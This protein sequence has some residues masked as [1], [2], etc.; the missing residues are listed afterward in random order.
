MYYLRKLIISNYIQQ[1]SN[2]LK[3]NAIQ[4]NQIITILLNSKDSKSNSEFY[5]QQENLNSYCQKRKNLS[6]G[7]LF[8]LLPLKNQKKFILVRYPQKVKIELKKR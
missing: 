2:I 4:Y 7:P 5:L 8:E 6:N 1:K 3:S